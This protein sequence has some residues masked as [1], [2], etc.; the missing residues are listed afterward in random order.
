MVAM[1]W[2]KDVAE[3]YDATSAAMFEPAVLD[4]VVDRLVELA[5]DGAA[6]EHM[7]AG[8]HVAVPDEGV[9]QR[10]GMAGPRSVVQLG[11]AV[12]RR[13]QIRSHRIAVHRR[14]LSDRA[15]PARQGATA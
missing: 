1:T 13:A 3:V 7:I 14:T 12:E 11:G 8:P 5:R 10:V 6:L 9:E 15:T 2:E 4:P